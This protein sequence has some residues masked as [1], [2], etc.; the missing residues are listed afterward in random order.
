MALAARVITGAD[1]TEDLGRQIEQS[2][3]ELI[4]RQQPVANELRSV[5]AM[6]EICRDLQR[7]DHYIVEVAKHSVRMET[8]P[9]AGAWNVLD[10]PAALT[11]RALT[12]AV[13]AY[14][15]RNLEAALRV[16]AEE[17]QQDTEYVDAIKAL[18]QTIRTDAEAVNSATEMVFVVT[19]LERIAEHSLNIAWQAK[20]MNGA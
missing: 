9:S 14:R 2:C 19:S 16:L 17:P 15:N 6:F 18:Q 1:Q 13:D 4:W 20:E 10:G 7:V 12:G 5:L 8:A 11:E 3:I